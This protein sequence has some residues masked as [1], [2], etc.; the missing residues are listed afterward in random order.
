MP[1]R[2]I[3]ESEDS[4]NDQENS[5]PVNPAKQKRMPIKSRR[6]KDSGLLSVFLYFKLAQIL[7]AL[8]SSKWSAG[9]WKLAKKVKKLER[10]KRNAKKTCGKFVCANFACC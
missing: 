7:T 1:R 10:E 5:P 9:A 8:R 2:Q 4:D 6:Q 3:I